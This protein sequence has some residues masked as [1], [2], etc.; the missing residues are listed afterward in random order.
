MTIKQAR[1]ILGK[2]SQDQSDDEVQESIDSGK[3]L[4]DIIIDQYFKMSPQERKDW[5]KKHK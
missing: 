1:R 2:Q 3:V 4:A 5:H